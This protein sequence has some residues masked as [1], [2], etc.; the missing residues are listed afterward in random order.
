MTYTQIEWDDLP[1]TIR[2]GNFNSDQGVAAEYHAIVEPCDALM[3]AA[4][5][6]LLLDQAVQ[7]LALNGATLVWKHY[8]LSDAINQA[9]YLRLSAEEALSAVQQ[10]PLNGSKVSLWLYYVENAQMCRTSD[11]VTLMKRPHYTHLF[12]TRLHKRSTVDSASPLLALPASS[13]HQT[14]QILNSY[15]ESLARHGCSLER[16]CIRTW[17]YVQDI[18]VQYAGMVEARREFF[19][20][21]GLTP[22]THF[23][24]STGIEGRY[25]YPDVLLHMD[26]YAIA[27]IEPSQVKYLRAPTHLNPTH[28]YGV[29]FERGTTVDYGDR[30]HIFI[31][32][33]ASINNQG[34]IEHPLEIEKQTVRT[35]ENVKALLAEAKATMADVMIMIVYLRDTADYPVVDRYINTHYPSIPRLILLAPVC[36]P[37]WL[38]EVECIAVKPLNNDVFSTF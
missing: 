6:F 26:A 1:V 32:G 16:N 24:A 5:Q 33:T 2:L 21:E 28:K 27:G 31:S 4:E 22:D 14:S 35:F 30:R 13:H 12:H 38:I 29:T 7:R 10:P 11:G 9:S 3:Q 23:I 20:G 18:D 25:Y 17:I 19:K 8:F 34:Q 36:R 37:R 15:T